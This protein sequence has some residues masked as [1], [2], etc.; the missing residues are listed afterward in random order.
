M[1]VPATL[2]DAAEIDPRLVEEA[3]FEALRGRPERRAWDRAREPLY[4]L[5]SAEE[6]EAAFARLN[7][8][9][10]R[11][12][13]LEEPIAAVLAD[14]REALR[15]VRRFVVIPARRGRD[16][17]AELFVAADGTRSVAV[18]IRPATLADAGGA[19]AL[20][21]RELLHVADMLDP[22]FL[23][24]PRL[25]AQPAGPAHDRLLQDRY[26]VLWDCAVDGRL[27]A[28]GRI[29]PEARAARHR[30]FR[31]VFP[32]PEGE[33]CFERIF[34]G[35]RPS[36]PDL[37]ALAARHAGETN[38]PVPGAAGEADGPAPRAA[39]EADGPAPRAPGRCAL[40]GFPTH[41]FEPDPAALPEEALAAIVE[42]FP[43]WDAGRPV[44][45][46]CADLYR[47]RRLSDEA[48]R[49]LPGIDRLSPPAGSPPAPPDREAKTRSPR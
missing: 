6:R 49:A 8:E 2:A 5:E 12:L 41:D 32:G 4:T 33:A 25:P 23:Y 37:V 17:A 24:E 42:D 10:F 39:G 45:R 20:L 9:W 26:R 34:A 40:C 44:C 15:P 35:P 16:Q 19:R 27:A 31:R 38:G 47:A 48:A 28:L 13:G 18:A 29:G 7:L 36:H 14:M 3:V 21:W 30:E 46:Q 43:E 22:A 11:R 1:S